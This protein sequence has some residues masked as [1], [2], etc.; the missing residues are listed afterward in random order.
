MLRLFEEDKDINKEKINIKE[1]IDYLVDTWERVTKETIINCWIKTGILPSLTNEDI[2]NAAQA[3]QERVDDEVADIDQIIRELNVAENP[4]GAALTNAIHDYIYDLEEI[5]TGDILN[6]DD[7][8]KLVQEEMRSDEINKNDS[9]EKEI[10]VY[11]SDALNAIQTWVKFFEQQQSDKFN[12][13]DLHIFK[14]YLK[15]TK[16]LEFQAK[17]QIPITQFF[18]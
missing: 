1:S 2:T 14:K 7:I 11:F 8:I 15:I 13:E 10:Q 16:Q 5:L 6:D 9:E 4:H 17:K 12:V 3:Q 18:N